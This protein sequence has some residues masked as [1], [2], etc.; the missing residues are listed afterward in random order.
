MLSLL[1]AS[2]SLSQAW[3]AL[4]PT[5]TTNLLDWTSPL[6]FDS[7]QIGQQPFKFDAYLSKELKK[8]WSDLGK[9]KL[10]PIKIYLRYG[11]QKYPNDSF[12][13]AVESGKIA[14]DVYSDK[15]ERP[16]R[17]AL[18]YLARMVRRKGSYLELPI[19]AVECRPQVAWR[20]VH[21][22]VGPSALAFHKKLW[23]NVLLP[24]GFNKVVLQCEQTEWN[25]LTNVRGGIAMKHAD[26]SKLCDWYRSVGVE[27]IP[28]VQSFGHADWLFQKGKNLG[29]ALNAKV[30]YAIDPR[31]PA[32]RDLFEQ[33]WREVIEVTKAKTVHFGLDEIALRGFPKDRSLATALWKV[34]LPFLASIAKRH[35]V[36]MM[37]WGDECLSPGQAPNATNAPNAKEAADRR[38]LIPK[39]SLI[40]DWHYGRQ[41]GPEGYLPTLKLLKGE[42]FKPVACTWYRPENIRN[43]V[44]AAIQEEAGVLQTTW[45]GYESSEAVMLKNLKQ[46]SAMILTADYAW[47]GR[48]EMSTRLGYDA[49]TAFLKLYGV[50]TTSGR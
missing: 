18:S 23:T 30:P 16:F 36:R 26:L 7:V 13:I 31:K 50:V 2:V 10:L 19:G 37:L 39:G 4:I 5:P 38:A 33:L 47:S 35:K 48:E 8:Q 21:L 45:A 24:L 1:I 44:L 22:F 27:P 28:L 25:C 32:A 15:S 41:P 49:N 34:Q 12:R 11:R 6:K 17:V 29:L 46:F 20:G 40:G 9:S 14:I 3:T 42:G 43:F